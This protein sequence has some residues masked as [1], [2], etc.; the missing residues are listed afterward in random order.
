MMNVV[1]LVVLFGSSGSHPNSG[2]TAIPQTNMQQCEVNK[3]HLIKQ[4][5]VYSVQCIVGGLPK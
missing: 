2:A 5:S 3:K 4:Q 1:F